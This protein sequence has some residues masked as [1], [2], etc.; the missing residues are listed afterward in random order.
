M[1]KKIAAA[2]LFCLVLALALTSCG[3]MAGP[4]P[5]A[6][7][8]D[9]KAGADET[10]AFYWYLCGSNLESDY[11]CGTDDLIELFDV[12]LP[13][14]VKFVIETGGARYWQNDTMDPNRIERYVYDSKG[15]SRIESL[16]Q[17]N[18]GRQSTLS[19]FLAFCKKNYEADHKVMLFWNH[20]GG[21]VAGAAFDE[22][23]GYDSLTI[24]E[25]RKA[26]M[27]VYELS[28]NEPPF[29]MVGFDT[30]LMATIDVADSLKDIASYLVASQETEG[31][32]GWYYTDWVGKFIRDTA[33]SGADLGKIICETYFN[34]CRRERISD[35]A[36]LSCTDLSKIGSLLKAY[37][38]FGEEA[39]M[40]AYVDNS[41]IAQF[42]KA[43]AKSEN[44]GGNTK[45]QGFTNMV[46]LGHMARLTEGLLASASKVS[47][48]LDECIVCQVKGASRSEATGLSFYYPYSKDLELFNKYTD[49]SA[50][51]AFDYLYQYQIKGSLDKEGTEYIK[52]IGAKEEEKEEVLSLASMGWDGKSLKLDK[53]GN[54]VLTLGPKANDI[55]SEIW[56][57]MYYIDEEA[58]VMMLL[59]VDNDIN[60]DWDKGVF[61]DNFRGV[62]GAIDDVMVYL[63]LS[64]AGDGYNLYSVPVLVNGEN[65]NL[66]VLYNFD[67]DTWTILGARQPLGESGMADK[68]MIQLEEGDEITVLWYLADSS[69][70]TFEPFD[71]YEFTWSDDCE[72]AETPLP[73]GVYRMI[74]DMYAANGDCV[75]AAPVDF[76]IRNGEITT[77]IY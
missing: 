74:I 41:F 77:T 55:L 5:D 34:G 28:E 52:T 67:S 15:F 33:I 8:G 48:G 1:K 36:T 27:N 38:D 40:A 61:T 44:Y 42:A 51:T 47:K 9:R 21:S 49:I 32:G 35:K 62:W 23:Y 19:D 69:F 12:K 70:E 56:F 24:D 11:G 63:E 10:W 60:A 3:Q 58:D 30:C 6:A 64:Y 7:E 14:N 4:M 29:E 50:G 13:S 22:N 45:S 26:F 65:Y 17:A 43:A 66:D 25:M 76:T 37:E 53:N 72:F 71:V 75:S 57:S 39:L 16:E 46:D 20:G 54:A 68:N 59:G 18:M 73:D 2:I 31:S